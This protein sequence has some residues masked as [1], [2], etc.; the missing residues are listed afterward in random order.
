MRPGHTLRVSL[1]H[2][3]RIRGVAAQ[4]ST[5][6]LFC[7]KRE[8]LNNLFLPLFLLGFVTFYYENFETAFYYEIFIMNILL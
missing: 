4:L 1:G 3:A 5:W 8:P 2:E 7:R 6:T